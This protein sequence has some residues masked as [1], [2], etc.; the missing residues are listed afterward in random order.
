MDKSETELISCVIPTHN[1]QELLKR[2]IESVITQTYK[3]LEIIV[4]DDASQDN[5]E[6]VVN[7]YIKRDSRIKYY[8][9]NK[10]LGVSGARNVGIQAAKGEFIAFLD[11]DD[12]WSERKISR[13][14]R[15]LENYAAVLCSSKTTW[16]KTETQYDKP[17]IELV[18]LKKGTIFG[19]GSSLL[20]R[21]PIMKNLL[22]DE[23]LDKGEDWDLLI[24]LST[25]NII[26][27]L[28]DTLVFCDDGNH[29]RIT[30][31]F[32]NKPISQLEKSL[33]IINKHK[34]FFGQRWFN[35]H[36]ADRLLTYISYRDNK[37]M[38]IFYISRRC[39]SLPVLRSL[40]IKI[41]KNL[42]SR[43][44]NIIQIDS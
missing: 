12:E 40:F 42:S 29:S 15:A 32:K 11:D 2:A 5:T 28:K 34:D 41:Q 19:A 14:M 16:S 23:K 27:F 31:Q 20:V 39:G 3:N 30:N 4:V 7:E 33:S 6:S 37:I 25:N 44:K 8:K 17:F 24:R 1:R 10:P 9:N 38:H 43:L 26:V 13:Q 21:V 22:F 35:Y 18:D 36:V